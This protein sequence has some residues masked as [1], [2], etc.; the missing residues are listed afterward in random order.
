MCSLL[1]GKHIGRNGDQ[2]L[3]VQYPGEEKNMLAHEWVNRQEIQ[4]L[5]LEQM[6]SADSQIK[7]PAEKE[8]NWM[9]HLWHNPEI[10][11]RILPNWCA[12]IS[13]R[14]S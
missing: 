14:E 7:Y 3:C 6:I 13:R 5:L 2:G 10:L 12:H 4:Q 8:K 1:G 9:G 11:I